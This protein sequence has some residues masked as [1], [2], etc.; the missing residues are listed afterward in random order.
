MP[1][2]SFPITQIF[3]ALLLLLVASGAGV[4]TRTL[5]M[6]WFGWPAENWKPFFVMLFFFGLVILFVKVS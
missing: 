2:I 3:L 5:S 6:R 4:L 1:Q